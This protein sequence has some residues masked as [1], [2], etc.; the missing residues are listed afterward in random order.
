LI[1]G[2]EIKTQ[3]L[4]PLLS[5]HPDALVQIKDGVCFTESFVSALDVYFRRICRRNLGPGDMRL[6]EHEGIVVH[7][8]IYYLVDTKQ[9]FSD[10]LSYR[11]QI[12]ALY[13]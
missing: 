7:A 1:A 12:A 13:K 8:Y 10:A 3:S 9:L 11:R 5:I 4:I 6:L 2:G